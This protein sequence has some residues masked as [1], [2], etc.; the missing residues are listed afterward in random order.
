MQNR[1]ISFLWIV[2]LLVSAHLV[3]AADSA[4]LGGIGTGK[5][6]I[7]SDGRLAEFTINHNYHRPINDP[8]G[9]F[10][11]VAVESGGGATVKFLGGQKNQTDAV[12]AARVA[13]KYP[14]AYADYESGDLPVKIRLRAFSPMVPGELDSS[15]YP[16]AQ[17]EYTVEN[18]T[19]KEIAV[20][21]AMS[22]RNFIGLGGTAQEPCD[23][24]G[25]VLH[26]V[27]R[28]DRMTGIFYNLN[29]PT[30][31]GLQ[32]NTLGE[33]ALVYRASGNEKP[34]LLP[35]WKPDTDP[36]AFISFL[37]KIGDAAKSKDEKFDRTLYG[38]ARPAA[39]VA[40]KQT[41][42]AGQSRTFAF[43]LAWRIPYRITKDGADAGEYYAARWNS[44]EKIVAEFN[45][46]VSGLMEKNREWE[47]RFFLPSTI[48]DWLQDK[49]RNGMAALARDGVLTADGK[50]SMLSSHPEF[51][52]N[53]GSPEERLADVH[54]FLQCFPNLLLSELERFT[55][56]QLTNGEV[57]SAIGNVYSTIGN[58]NVP[59]G[60]IGNPDSSAAYIL[61]I[62]QYYLWTG[63]SAFLKDHYQHVR[64]ALHWLMS[65]DA[66]SDAIPDGLSLWPWANEGNTALF[67]G[68]LAQAAFRIGEELEQIY[69]DLEF[70]T[71]CRQQGE[72]IT[73]NLGSQLW[74]GNYYNPFF[75]PRRPT[76]AENAKLAFGQLPG[77]WFALMQG[78]NSFLPK[79]RLHRIAQCIAKNL[80]TLP[81]PASAK[82][83]LSFRYGF[84]QAF[85]GPLLL[86]YGYGDD[87]EKLQEA[88]TFN[89]ELGW[90]SYYA[91]L[92]GVGL[93][94]HRRCLFVGPV[95]S[96]SLDA[97][98]YPFSSP[99]FSG[100][101][102]LNRSPLS[103]QQDCT[104][105]IQNA[106]SGK[107]SALQQV[108]F[109]FPQ[110]ANV[111]EMIVQVDRNGKTLAG[112]DFSRE[113]LRAFGFQPPLRLKEGDAIHLFLTSKE[114]PRIV[115]D[116]QGREVRNYGGKCRIDNIGSPLPGVSFYVTN[117]LQE[118]QLLSFEITNPQAKQDYAIFVNGEKRPLT[119]PSPEPV[120]MTLP[121]SEIKPEE[122]ASLHLSVQACQGAAVKLA[123]IP[124]K[125]DLK[126][127][128]WE[129]QEE[130][131]RLA[132]LDANQRGL[133]ID[134]IPVAAVDQF[135]YTKPEAAGKT[136][137]E[138]LDRL[139]ELH[140]SFLEYLQKESGDPVLASEIH[141]FFV[142]AEISVAAVVRAASEPLPVEVQVRNPLRSV[143]QGRLTMNL[144]E[145]WRA[146][147]ND[148]VVFDEQNGSAEERRF[149]FIVN[150]PAD[151]WQERFSLRAVFSGTWNGFPFRKVQ[152]TYA[153]HNF[154]KRWM[155]VGPF[156]N[157]RGEGFG[158]MNPPEIN[159]K[160]KESYDGFGK[161]VSWQEHEF[162]NGYVD[163]D[164]ILTPN[165]NASAYAY[166]G[167]YSPR[168]Q[169]VQ[170]LVGCNGDLKLFL[171]YK[172][173]YAKRNEGH[174]E[175]GGD[176]IVHRLFE[177]WNHLVVKLSERVAAWGFYFEIYDLQGKP[178]EGMQFA[179]DKAEAQ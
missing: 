144:P 58:G 149:H 91:A 14:Y 174:P 70:Q 28:Q 38:A 19:Q 21:M 178:I 154:V 133:R 23:V 121:L 48:P 76:A 168:E 100:L 172:E 5:I 85:T 60:L 104:V 179:F 71:W 166:T 173:I 169:G 161:K 12:P 152:E 13:G 46:Q 158:K 45:S 7:Q 126:K 116:I 108:A 118:R 140:R 123:S 61:L 160:L 145:G 47:K 4:I 107:E 101:I 43:V 82:D 129:L 177:G 36:N 74:N 72:Q 49:M 32:R 75:D 171:N 138:N 151:L 50:F 162:P 119:V 55:D 139:N 25:E 165:D 37:G 18:P 10:A 157:E 111:N 68:S 143:L 89:P 67:S 112:Q 93:D 141:G 35:L 77:E 131:S 132:E 9:C 113:S 16:A 115:V 69:K 6:E 96:A 97:L 3:Y 33:H 73:R 1:S 62:Y 120:P 51:P 63:D 117:Q 105:E 167:V 159:I 156:P 150:A 57:P 170:F 87:A 95:T 125:E 65:R 56:C 98:V 20:T 26:R 86:R 127:R 66:N 142:P 88:E 39:A 52:G 136:L 176:I 103:G 83:N 84:A 146:A 40:A 59:G 175:P 44:L 128:L 31:E 78:W 11:A 109:L 122:I 148:D 147:T 79:D 24:T 27:Y 164:S 42:P 94:M 29:S 137:R 53:L 153:G 114:G 135:K 130:V 163:F 110:Y 99:P 8:T 54:F 102:R 41:I 81:A 134:V 124:G 64:Y 34:G 30:Q 106:P 17:F 22:W 92:S 80:A 15:C 155:I 2:A 90:W